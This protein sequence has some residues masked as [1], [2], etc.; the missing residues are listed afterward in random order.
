[1][2]CYTLQNHGSIS[3]GVCSR[4][5]VLWS[6]HLVG[7]IKNF[8]KVQMRATILITRIKDLSYIERLK[9][10]KLP[11][12]KYRRL[13]GDMIELHKIITGII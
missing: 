5:L 3:F 6:S 10:L 13:R 9:E 2:L 8:E 11:T 7:H 12:L 1:M 4:S